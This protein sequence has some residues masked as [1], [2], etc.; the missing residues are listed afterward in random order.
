MSPSLA[1][2]RQ[3]RPPVLRTG[4]DEFVPLAAELG[5]EFAPRAAEHDRANTFV[6]ENFDRMRDAGY[7]KLAVPTELGGRGARWRHCCGP[8]PDLARSCP[9]PPPAVNI[10]LSQP[11]PPFSRGRRGAPAAEPLLRRIAADG[12]VVMSSG[13]SDGLWPSG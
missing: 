9:P 7:L 10:P 12:I 4:D 13:G 11:P 6:T 3:F 1:P 8:R 2:T 5:A